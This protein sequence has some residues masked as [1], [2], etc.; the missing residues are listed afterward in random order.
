MMCS[1]QMFG[2]LIQLWLAALPLMGSPGPAVLGV[3]GTAAAFGARRALP[4]FLGIVMGTASVLLLIATGLTGL[5]WAIPGAAPVVGVAAATYILYLAYRIATAP[6]LSKDAESAEAPSLV[7]GYLLAIA[8]PKAFAA[9]GAL[10]AGHTLAPDD[11]IRDAT[12]KLLGL[13]MM[14]VFANGSWLLFGAALSGLLRHPTAGRIA[15]ITFAVLLVG[16]VALALL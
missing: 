6:V 12:L 13:S 2:D 11:P 15:N 10:Y 4:Y 8:N 14:I 5:L 16:S 1:G 9:L 7:A 3:A